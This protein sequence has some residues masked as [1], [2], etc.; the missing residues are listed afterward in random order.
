MKF[1]TF[2]NI[3]YKHR[4][5][6]RSNI[7]RKLYIIIIIPFSYIIE[8]INFE[9]KID[10]DK[11]QNQN[12]YLY[13]K[14][15]NFL[16]QYFH[17]DKGKKFINQYARYSKRKKDLIDGHGY[18]KFYEKHL[19]KI[20]RKK[21]NIFEIGSFKGNATASLFFYL[22]NSKIY[23]ADLYP[24]LFRYTSKRIMNFKIDNSSEYELNSISK[25]IKYDLIIEDAGHYLKDQIITLFKLFPNLK[26]NGLFVIEELD[27]PDTRKD[28][29]KEK[30]KNTLY[31]ILKLVIKKKD[32]KSRFISEK[33]KNFFLKNYKKI[34]IYKGKFNKIAFVRKK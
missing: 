27:F 13:K 10:L 21:L 25:K 9:K 22:K 18:A 4:L 26:K 5:N 2:V 33:D 7:F 32:F 17:S 12:K 30:D 16:F 8:K 20:K 34:D 19:I 24:D 31:K 15:L 6:K 11:F 23:S 1:N 28:M 14:N 3:Y 29:N